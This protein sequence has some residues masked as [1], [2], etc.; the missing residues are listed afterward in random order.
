M[1][2]IVLSFGKKRR[3]GERCISSGLIP[4]ERFMWVR[5]SSM[6]SAVAEEATM[7]ARRF[8]TQ[9][10]WRPCVLSPPLVRHLGCCAPAN[11][12]VV[13]QIL[14]CRF[15]QFYNATQQLHC[16]IPRVA[17]DQTQ[18]KAPNSTSI[19]PKKPI[20]SPKKAFPCTKV[21]KTPWTMHDSW[22]ASD[23]N[24]SHRR[25]CLSCLNIFTCSMHA[26]VTNLLASQCYRR[27]TLW[28]KQSS[29]C[30]QVECP[31]ALSYSYFQTFS[32]TRR[33]KRK[34]F[35]SAGRILN[36]TLAAES[37]QLTLQKMLAR[38]VSSSGLNLVEVLAVFA[39][40]IVTGR[41]LPVFC[42]FLIPCKQ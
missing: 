4:C 1:S 17:E 3:G 40:P 11:H 28:H 32:C 22:W 35:S 6:C 42:R 8:A 38:P 2:I 24:W 12:L 36:I 26:V 7:Q 16:I 14:Y 23:Q 13:L 31:E 18:S 15:C 21:K 30:V 34:S 39:D 19:N 27:P 5:M 20:Y 10:N 29:M 41:S 37:S 33:R 9:G 25:L